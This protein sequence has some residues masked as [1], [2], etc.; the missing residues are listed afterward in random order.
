MYILQY[1]SLDVCPLEVLPLS[2]LRLDG[3][4][5]DR[6]TDTRLHS[7]STTGVLWAGY[8]P[9]PACLLCFACSVLPL[10]FPGVSATDDHDQQQQKQRQQHGSHHHI[11]RWA[12]ELSVRQSGLCDVVCIGET[13]MRRG[14][15]ASALTH[16]SGYLT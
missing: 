11:T 2:P 3:G 7:N 16:A 6:M 10:P 15:E 14:S 12:G 1:M 8:L 5:A 13:L 4:L 9:L